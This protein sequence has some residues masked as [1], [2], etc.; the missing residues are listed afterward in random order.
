MQQSREYSIG[1]GHRT[2]SMR[3][4]KEVL[5]PNV[6]ETSLPTELVISLR[7]DN[8]LAYADFP[9]VT[10]DGQIGFL[11]VFHDQPHEFSRSEVDL[12]QTFAAQA[13]LAVAN[14]QLHTRTDERLTRRVHQLAMLES[15]SRELSAA[16]HSDQL[17]GL[18]LDYALEFTQAPLGAIILPDMDGGVAHFKAKYGYRV[19]EKM[20]IDR[21]ISM[22]VMRTGELEN[23]GDVRDDP[24]FYDVGDGDTRSQLSVPLTYKNEVLGVLTLESPILNAFP[25]N[26]QSLVE[27]LAN[28][29]AVALANANL[30]HETQRHLREQST[31]FQITARLVK[32]L[33]ADST[34]DILCQALK[35]VIVP[36]RLAFYFLNQE[37]YKFQQ[38][39]CKESLDLGWIQNELNAN[40]LDDLQI[41]GTKMFLLEGEDALRKVVVDD[42]VGGRYVIFPMR[43]AQ[44]LIGFVLFNFS[45]D[46]EISANLGKLVEA[47]VAQGAIAFQNAQLFVETAQRREELAAVIN[48]V[49]ESIIMINTEGIVTL[50]NQPLSLLTGFPSDEIAQTR[51]RD[52]SDG[53]LARL[54][55]RRKELI[56]VL[57]NL[58][59]SR[60][61]ESE[62]E[63][64]Q[65]PGIEPVSV[66]ER[67]SYPVMDLRDQVL[68]WMIVWRDVTEEHKLNQEREAIADA[69]IHD[70]R[71]P[72]SAVLGAVDLLDTAIPKDVPRELVDRSLQV[73]RRGAKRV[74][75]LIMSLLDVARMQSG[76]IELNRSPV[77]LSSLIIELLM[78]I[79]IIADEYHINVKNEVKDDLPVIFVD[80][81][82]ISRV[83]TNLLDNAVKFSPEF[84]DVRVVGEATDDGVMI[85]IWD[86]GPGISEEYRA[87]IFERFS[88][89][90]GQF[91][92]W[93]GAGLGLAFSRLTAEAHGGTISVESPPEGTGSV[94]TLTLPFR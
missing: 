65:V 68:G 32:A 28:Q 43:T 69:L 91:G 22:R 92:R 93:R 54:G 8:I 57:E 12:L 38:L 64:Y 49:A 67:S 42:S 63:I 76:R 15:V 83:I 75:R 24:D 66:I 13:A 31:L 47:I 5:T 41:D 94:F 1:L 58:A 18:V 81:D 46:F 10:P 39:S 26:E 80:E 45:T 55:Y 71:S 70:L 2:R 88:Q 59:E 51:L 89:I 9:L 19:P 79:E 17:F 30:Y 77:E 82:K 60:I 23:I 34:I 4:G 56:N 36:Q 84:G 6:A 61:P 78:D 90:S 62:R 27:Q 72:I 44:R 50:S 87:I 29:A 14:A 21:G 20:V 33:D 3:T 40:Y 85:Q 73:A 52:L 48:S 16:T 74:L 53:V 35:A 86:Q 11:S 7:I 37:N 25:H